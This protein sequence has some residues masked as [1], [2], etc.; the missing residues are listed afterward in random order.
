[1]IYVYDCDSCWFEWK[2]TVLCG[3]CTRCGSLK[4]STK[5]TLSNENS[6]KYLKGEPPTY[7]EGKYKKILAS[8]VIDDFELSHYKAS[9]LEYILRS[10]KKDDERQDIQKAINH[11]NLH[12]N[13]LNKKD[14]KI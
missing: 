11:L 6:G 2:S 4:I 12:I 13:Y 1:M 8:D 7:Y 10:G 5:K 3:K 9:A 14:E